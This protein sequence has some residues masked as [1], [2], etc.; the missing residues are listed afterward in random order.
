MPRLG[1]QHFHYAH[2]RKFLRPLVVH[3]NSHY[4]MLSVAYSKGVLIVALVEE[5]AQDESCATSLGDTCEELN[6]IFKIGLLA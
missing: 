6:G 3:L 5:V 2:V 4:I 1:I